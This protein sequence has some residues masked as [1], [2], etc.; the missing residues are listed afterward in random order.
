MVEVW[1]APLENPTVV[2]AAWSFCRVTI[3]VSVGVPA[4]V[5]HP[6]KFTLATVGQESLTAFW[7]CL[8]ATAKFG[9]MEE[10]A[11]HQTGILGPGHFVSDCS[12]GYVLGG[13][14]PS[15]PGKT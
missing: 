1:T 5:P 12:S 15:A 14:M 13:P 9:T 4:Q 6:V 11:V 8:E 3:R 2:D 7:N 10:A